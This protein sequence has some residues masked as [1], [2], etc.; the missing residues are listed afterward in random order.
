MNN[1]VYIP[2]NTPNHLAEIYGEDFMIPKVYSYGDRI[3]DFEILLDN[4]TLGRKVE[5]R[6]K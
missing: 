3:K 2:D 6:R 5:F 4:Q 1:D